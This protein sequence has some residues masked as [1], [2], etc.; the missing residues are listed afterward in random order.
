MDLL[1]AETSK[2]VK[3]KHGFRSLKLVNVDMDQVLGEQ[4]V[5]V[6][7]G[8]LD[9]GL[10]YY[11]RCNS[12]PRM[13]AALALAVK[14]GSVLEEENERGVAHIVEH[15]AFSA[16]EKYTN[17]DIIR[18]LESIGAEFGACQ[19]AVTSADD[20]VYE[21]FVPV[22]K[23]ELLSQAISV[24]AEFSS[25]VRVSKDDLERE[26]GAVMEEY[27]GNR[28]ATGR[29]QD[30]HW[31]LMME[32]SQY[33]DR[34]P[35]GLEKV[36]R[37][38]S[39]ETVK[40]FYSKWYHLS[41][42][43]V[44]AVGDFSDTQSVVELIKNHFGHKI[45]SPELP[46]IPRYTV[47]S[48]EE[49]RFS[50]FVESEA[51]GSAVI[52]SY[53][54]A[55]GELNTVRDYRDLL[56]ESMFL[57]ALNQRFFKI[58]RRKDP[59]Y[60]SCSA[61]ADVLVNP[62][63]AY[64]MTSS[65][66]EKGTIEALESMLTEVARVQLHGFSEREVSIVRALLMSEIESAYL[67]RDQM[68]STSL[69][70][71]YLQHF[72]RNEPVIGI[73][74]EAQLQKTLL[75]QITT[76][77]I[78][79]YAV[80]LQTSCSCVIKTIE[81][82]ASATIG[83]LKNVVSM[84]NDLEEKRIISP[85]DD[86]QIPEE[87]VNSKPNPGNIVQELEYSKIGVTELV[88][89]NGMRVCYKCTNFL[90]DQVIFT[91]FSYGGL[92]ELPESEYFSCSM[93][94]TIAGEIGV[95]GYR[96]SVLMDMLAGKR[97]EVS[98]KLGAYMRTFSGD[99]SPS[100][101][102]TALQL[103]YQL[104]TTNVTPGEED[105]KIVMQMAEEVVRA[106]D[107]DPYTAFA[108]R[109][110]ELNYGNSYFFRPIRISDLRK[111]DPLKACEYFNKCFKDPSTFS[112]VI[113]GNI[114]PSIA[115]PLIL[116]YLGGIPNPPEPVLQYNRDDL[117]GLPFT[118][119]KT[120]IR[121][122]V[123]SPMVEEQCSVQLCFPVELNNGTMVEDI[124]VIGFL[125]K[126][127]ETKIMQVLRFKHGQIYT[128]G[129]S[130]FLGGNKP[131]RTANVRGD[132]SINFSCDPEISSKLVDLTL[133]EISRLQEEGPSDEDVSTIL[134]IEQRAHENGLQE[135]YYWLDR[136]LHSYQSRVYSGDVGTCFEIQEEG[137]SKVRQSLTP[138]TAQL[139]LQ[140][141]LPFPCKKQYTVVIL[142]PRTSHFKSLR[143]FFQSTETSYGR[144]AKILAGIAGL[145]VLALSLW[146]YSRR[147]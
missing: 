118:F 127:L 68:Q 44:I 17:H 62:L 16:T 30:A 11:V 86:E 59:P 5:G 145:T 113:V 69:R 104:F 51:T 78:S 48:H 137:R 84:I 96:P 50:C 40:Q 138:V 107:R 34:L 26:R 126:L 139:A 38:V 20:T 2:I 135:N 122:V 103:V 93:G 98:T 125:S 64:I 6:D 94:P 37:T 82:R 110:K 18:F 74:Y 7:Y 13:R 29:M 128:V 99:C 147:P 129:V 117:K 109:V 105:V 42:M 144:H 14:V 8:R 67:E 88:L 112:I 65:C 58:A 143:S 116:Q 70:D 101:L 35:I 55:A 52:I 46:L 123:H 100:D 132:I 120:R 134:E 119:P 23:H 87:I 27:R 92:S 80:K 131:S 21:L 54:M 73:E 77:E 111:V 66:K 57:Y 9:N 91:G 97:A 85:W 3:K 75:P 36:I 90:D 142:M 146:R 10:C 60:F 47:P 140:K 25:E 39:S 81:P 4:P 12:K 102:E 63:K 1:P 106:Q 61:S 72:L 95:Y 121:E 108:N 71:E 83:D 49:P 41:N 133:D 141:I 136:I 22:D 76:A 124:H 45:S 24:L 130:V 28:N 32:G 56:A 89:S 115:L 43:A 31:I 19:N 33:A 79:K 15:L 114:D 53:K